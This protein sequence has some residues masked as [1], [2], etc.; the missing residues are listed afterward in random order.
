MRAAHSIKGA[1]R[2]VNV[3]P[4]VELR[5]TYELRHGT[6]PAPDNFAKGA[7]LQPY[8]GQGTTN[9]PVAI[10]LQSNSGLVGV[11]VSYETQTSNCIAF[12]ATIQGRGPN[13]YVVGVCCPNPYYYVDL[14]SYTCTNH[15]I[16]MVDGWALKT[17]YQVGRGSSGTIADCHG[18][19]TYWIDNYASQSTLPGSA[20]PKRRCC[21]QKALCS[22]G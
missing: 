6:W 15:F 17:G 18:N 20:S 2:V 13:V 4:G 10:A 14:D 8:G 19:W 16:Y 12:P 21:T 9:G 22:S 3:P 5:G 1:A 7:V 11:T